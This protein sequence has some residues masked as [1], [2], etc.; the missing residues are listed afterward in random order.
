MLS[1][2]HPWWLAGLGLI[3][4]IRWLHRRQAP[5]STHQ[6][7]ALFLWGSGAKEDEA[8]HSQRP[9]D[10]AWRRRAFFATLLFV[11]LASPAIDTGVDS[12]IVWIDPSPSMQ[13]IEN[14]ETRLAAAERA[15]DS[16]LADLGKVR[17]ASRLLTSPLPQKLDRQHGNWL[18]SDGANDHIREWAQTSG[19]DRVI[20][21]GVFT[22]NS[23]VTQ[24][25]IRRD[26]NDPGVFQV[27]VS[28]SHAGDSRT[29]RVLS[30]LDSAEV[31][32]SF[33]LRM[34]PGQTLHRQI[35][36]NM[37]T[38]TLTASLGPADP[39]RDDDLLAI[40][41]QDLRPLQVHIGEACPGRLRT[42]LSLHPAL[43]ITSTSASGDLQVTCGTE[44]ASA[45]TAASD[46]AFV[47]HLH[48]VQGESNPVAAEP[49]WFP[50][51]G[52]NGALQ[53]PTGHLRA[54]RWPE[55]LDKAIQEPVL[56]AKSEPLILI[57]RSPGSRKFI[58]E[59]VIDFQN[60]GFAKQA[61]YAGL[62]AAL[63]DL[64][65]GRNTLDS[66]VRQSRNVEGIAIRP[67][68]VLVRNQANAAD[69]NNAGTHLYG[70]LLLISIF[71]IALDLLLLLLM[72]R[73]ARHE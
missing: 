70:P 31:L 46:P 59:T 20:Q 39:L 37:N 54:V 23:A 55:F 40:P 60:T 58:V 27:L 22:D 11:A 62:V 73:R 33:E 2:M 32:D 38:K 42:A 48:F 9:P 66:V 35:S 12:V 28:A 34:E 26:L 13:V 67:Q 3:P 49:V 19:F 6:V 25:A 29:E 51:A 64:A 4:L 44:S 65:F 5:L 41:F 69:Q 10:P 63:V 24:L 72:R 18:V 36:V 47:A 52:L 50:Q 57:L 45:P 16:E 17:I 8:G 21:P 15:L 61:S 30:I 1:L 7:S 68:T 56:L 71:V 43:S 53:V 14:G